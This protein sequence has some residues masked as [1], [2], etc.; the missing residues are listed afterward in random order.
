M[1]EVT[2]LARCRNHGGSKTTKTALATMVAMIDAVRTG[3]TSSNSSV[4]NRGQS[5]SRR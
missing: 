4:R 2:T 1:A 5:Q 3:S